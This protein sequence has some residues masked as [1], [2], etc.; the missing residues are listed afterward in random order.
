MYR[1]PRRDLLKGAVSSAITASGITARLTP[2]ARAAGPVMVGYVSPETGPLAAFGSA[3]NFVI[4]ALKDQL[5]A[6]GIRLEV[7]DT[8]SDPALAASVANELI[9]SNAALILVSS[10]PETTNPVSDQCELAGV[11]CISTAAPWQA[12]FFNRGGDPV[13]GFNYTYHFFWGLED[14]LGVYTGMWNQL[15]TN[16]TVGA[17]FPDDGD[18]YAWGN[19]NGGFPPA[20]A[21]QYFKLVTLGSFED[22]SSDFSTQIALYEASQAQIITGVLLPQDFVSIW[23]IL[24]HQQLRPKIATIG[25][26]LLFP[27]TLQQLGPSGQN[28]STEVWWTPQSPFTSSLTKETPRQLTDAYTRTT[29]NQW[30]QPIGFA[31]ALC[32]LAV[33]VI[34]RST[35]PTNPQKVLEALTTTNLNTIVGP[36]SWGNG[37]V[38]NV[39]K[40][41]LA[42]GQWRMTPGGPFT[43]D[44]VI[45]ETGTAAGIVR[46]GHM[47]PI[48]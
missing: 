19:A 25:K 24:S 2:A 12:W 29:G 35:D 4:N 18:G 13:T 46:G 48:W 38:K 20:L 31:H 22:L 33:D 8:R 40:T 44:I 26:A 11:P 10:T 21:Q 23:K 43:Y 5:D 47:Q 6:K 45:T 3:D 39:C 7:R 1:I 15:Q 28:L 16:K 37:P 17:L 32:E 41:P 9:N 27:E 42:G 34:G 36:V 30:I 14:V